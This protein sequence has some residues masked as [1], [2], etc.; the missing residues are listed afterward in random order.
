MYVETRE[1][2]PVGEYGLWEACPAVETV[3]RLKLRVMPAER[4]DR[5]LAGWVVLTPERQVLHIE[6]PSI[7]DSGKRQA[8]AW[9]YD[10]LRKVWYG[11]TEK[12][13]G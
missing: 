13:D 6:S 10:H 1:T 4:F 5:G 2:G 3:G 12:V 9:A 11:E 7:D 8:F